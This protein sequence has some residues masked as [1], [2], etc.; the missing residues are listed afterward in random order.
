[1][2]WLD[3]TKARLRSIVAWSSVAAAAVPLL[4]AACAGDAPVE[5]ARQPDAAADAPSPP[6]D[7]A[8]DAGVDPD[9]RGAFDPTD[10][11]VVCDASPCATQ[12]VAGGDHFCA[13]FRDGN[14]RCWGD[15][16]FGATGTAPDA[17]PGSPSD[18]DAGSTVQLIA[19]LD[20]VAEL[21]AAG[22]TTCARLD[23][24]TVKCWGD[25][26]H[27]QLGLEIDPPV[28]DEAPH[29]APSKV[30]LESAAKHVG[31]GHGTVCAVLSNG[32]L[33]C[34]GKDDQ[35]QLARP[36]GDGGLDWAN[37]VRGPGVAAIEPLTVVRT[38]P[39][40]FTVLALGT[41][42]EVWSWGAVAGNLG[43][44]SGRIAS[45]SP[46]PTPKR[47]MSLEKVTSI[48]A[49][50][51]VEVPY[52]PPPT[53]PGEPAPPYKPPPPR[54][55]ACALAN[56][57][58]Y[59][60]GQSSAG[61]LCTG[62]PDKE[63]E[64]RRAPIDAKTWPQQL[65]VA[66]EITCARMTDG[67]IHCCGSDTRGRL[68]TGSVGVLSARFSKADAFKG[69]AVQVATSDR[70]VC[71]LVQDGTVECWGSNEKGELGRAPDQADH[72]SPVKIAF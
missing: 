42:G 64:P 3:D 7:G 13:R 31:V 22:A 51:Y 41:T 61:A 54:A 27:A 29:P 53:E 28:A 1:M 46:N 14:V 10:A 40:S 49:S 52:E 68:G 8:T 56:G 60:W 65:A 55:H 44:L 12:V 18:G 25:N 35:A 70:A 50:G 37:P 11:P 38:T 43:L 30:A 19:D 32:R 72:P 33:W 71:A 24:G 34:W 39:G 48:A 36:G 69:Y 17:E 2:R 4:A 66:D 47:I 15:P 6:D 9:T 20:G 45:V 23:D 16:A 58:V 63:Q 59:C 57:E 62:L 67:S 5:D 21:S 26:R